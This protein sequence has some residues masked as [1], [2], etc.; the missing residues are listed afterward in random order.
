MYDGIAIVQD[1]LRNSPTALSGRSLQGLGADEVVKGS[2]SFTPNWQVSGP[3]GTSIQLMA[4]HLQLCK[5]TANFS[6]EPIVTLDDGKRLQHARTCAKQFTP[7][8]SHALQSLAVLGS[9]LATV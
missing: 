2:A 1:P 9:A 6:R 7:Q 3:T 5:G 8:P 4:L